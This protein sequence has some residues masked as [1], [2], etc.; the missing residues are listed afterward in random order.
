MKVFMKNK[1]IF[2]ILF[3]AV[4]TSHSAELVCQGQTKTNPDQRA[5]VVNC[6]SR[7]AIIN[8]LEDAYKAVRDVKGARVDDC[9]KPYYE[10][11]FDLISNI[12][13]TRALPRLFSQCNQSLRLIK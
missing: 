11:K 5:V 13:L 4:T 2:L 9:Y 12:D 6:S 10:A 3:F 7:Q 1:F 8:T